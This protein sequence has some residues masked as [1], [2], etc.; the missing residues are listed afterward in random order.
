MGSRGKAPGQ[1]LS[2]KLTTFSYFRDIFSLKNYHINLGYIASV[3]A[4]LH[5]HIMARGSK[6]LVRRS[7]G[8]SPAEAD[9]IFLFQRLLS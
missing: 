1:G 3:G 6:P 2:L 8:R 4:R 5:Q 7:E 9:D